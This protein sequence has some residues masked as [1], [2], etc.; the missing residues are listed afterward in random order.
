MGDSR[1]PESR[2]D[3][4]T[5]GAGPAGVAAAYWM[6]NAALCFFSRIINKRGTKLFTGQADSLR[7]RTQEM[8]DS[9]GILHRVEQEGQEANPNLHI[10]RGVIAESLEY[11]ERLENDHQALRTLSDEEANPSSLSPDDWES[12][13]MQAKAKLGR[14]EVIKAMYVIGAD[15][16]HS[17]TRKQMGAKM[18]G[19]ASN[20]VWGVM[21]VVPISNFRELL[22]VGRRVASKLTRCNRI[23]IAGDAAHT[24]TPKAGVGMNISIQD[25]FNL[26]WKVASAAAGITKPEAI[27]HRYELVRHP[28]AKTL[29][30]FG[31]TWSDLFAN[32]RSAPRTHADG[33]PVWSTNIMKSD[34]RWHIV[35]LAGD[36]FVPA[37]R[38]RLQ[39]L[40][41]HLEQEDEDSIRRRFTPSE[42]KINSVIDVIAINS[43]P[44][45]SLDLFDLPEALRPIKRGAVAIMRPDQ[46]IG[47]LGDLEE[48]PEMRDYLDGVL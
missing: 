15:G 16:A 32:D 6:A 7:A 41:T 35:V 21:D 36:I 24:H 45:T 10:E 40:W 43:A 1:V 31:Q 34:G 19:E 25:G 30:E 46:Y 5:T 22:Q 20:V 2:T 28:V 23:F 48:A 26:G 3:V 47:W 39:S 14:V 9:M 29:F 12:S 4:L 27:L 8:F 17:C 33:L 44:R 13:V 38:A 18:E 37:Q 42:R 11:D